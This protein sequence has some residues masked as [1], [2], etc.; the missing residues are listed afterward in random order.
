MRAACKDPQAGIYGPGSHM[1]RINR[2]A[3]TFLGGGRAALLQTAH[4]WVAHGVDQHSD[5]K[6]DPIGRFQRTFTNVFSMVYG[7]LDQAMHKAHGVHN[8]H[9]KITGP[10]AEASGAFGADSSYQANEA[11]AMLWVHATLW[12]TAIHMR[13]LILGPLS[14][15]V[16]EAYYQETK[17]FAYLFGIPDEIIPPNWPEFLEYNEKM[18]ASDVLFVGTPARD[19]STFLF[20]T[21]QLPGGQFYL[22]WIELLTAGML[23]AQV[24]EGYGLKWGRKEQANYERSLKMVRAIYPRLPKTVR[25]LPAYQ[26]AKGR[27]KGR[28]A[29]QWHVQQLNKLMVGKAQL[30]S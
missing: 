7:T 13:E 24:R 25:Y 9:T 3:A 16:K 17:L 28:T 2:E 6:N 15:E 1:W 29:P 21:K 19:I 22:P 8:I 26:E 23:P 30:V 27:L 20:G 12:E 10:V 4:P 18:W 14:D 5:T 11:H